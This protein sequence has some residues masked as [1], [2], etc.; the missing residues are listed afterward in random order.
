MIVYG[1]DPGS[2][3]I[4]E[5]AEADDTI[6][7]KINGITATVDSGDA[8]WTHGEIKSVTLS[9]APTTIAM[10][11]INLPGPKAVAPADTVTFQVDVRNDGDGLDFYGVKLSMSLPGGSGINEWEA[12]EPDSVVYAN[13]D[14]TVSVFFSIKAPLFNIDTANTVTYTV[15]S[16]LDTTVTV[17]GDVDVFMTITDV[18]DPQVVLPGS[19]VLQQNYPNPFNPSTII[20]FNL[21]ARTTAR[22]DIIDILGR[23]VESRNLGDLPAGPHQVEYEADGLASGVYFYRLVTESAA[24]SRKMILLR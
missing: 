14:D 13:P 4:D 18:D 8:T 5:G 11:G 6:T 2:P 19:F 22:L 24:Q 16:H 21:S 3:G 23:V 10:A 1:D 20:A 12:L 17:G 9:A 15:F 7:F